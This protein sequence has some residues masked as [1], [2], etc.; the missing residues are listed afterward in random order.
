MGEVLEN[1]RESFSKTKEHQNVKRIQAEAFQED[2]KN[3]SKRVLQIDYTMAYQC[4]LQNQA[5]WALWT[6]GSVNLFTCA[7]YGNSDTKT[8][9]FGTN[10]KGKY[11]F[12]T[13]LFVE[14]LYRDYIFLCIS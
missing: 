12:S 2:I 8:L 11:N 13:G 3:P 6:R 4:E 5:M 10:Y 9:I 7:V 1:F 14:I